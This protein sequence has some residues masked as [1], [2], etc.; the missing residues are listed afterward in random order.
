MDVWIQSREWQVVGAF[1]SFFFPLF[2]FFYIYIYFFVRLDHIG[3]GFQ[4]TPVQRTVRMAR[5]EAFRFLATAA[6]LFSAIVIAQLLTSISADPLNINCP[7][8]TLF[9]LLIQILII[10]IYWIHRKD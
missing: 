3:K 8:L 10:V 1:H 6:L 4:C 7:H 5:M 2:F 9:F